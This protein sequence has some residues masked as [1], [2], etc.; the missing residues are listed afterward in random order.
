MGGSGGGAEKQFFPRHRLGEGGPIGQYV[1]LKI[2]M[3]ETEPDLMNGI[4]ILMDE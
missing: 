3:H 1:G 2:G 4:G